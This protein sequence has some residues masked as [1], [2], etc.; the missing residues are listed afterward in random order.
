MCPRRA[1]AATPGCRPAAQPTASATTS[2][3]SAR[4]PTVLRIPSPEALRSPPGSR[5]R[6]PQRY[7]HPNRRGKKRMPVVTAVCSVVVATSPCCRLS[8]TR[9]I[10][11]AAAAMPAEDRHQQG[12]RARSLGQQGEHEEEHHGRRIQRPAALAE[13]RDAPP[14]APRH[15]RAHPVAPRAGGCCSPATAPARMP[16]ATARR[17]RLRSR[18][19]RSDAPPGSMLCRLPL[20][21]PVAGAVRRTPPARPSPTSTPRAAAPQC[22]RAGASRQTARTRAGRAASGWRLPR[23]PPSPPPR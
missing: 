2:V 7:K 22:A 17:W 15:R 20:V 6:P 19:D 11:G 14:A 8:P 12:E 21:A 10:A 16:S 4:A 18:S 9:S 23:H 3:A 1:A 5:S 13:Q